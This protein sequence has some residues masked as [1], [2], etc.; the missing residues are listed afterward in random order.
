MNGRKVAASSQLSLANTRQAM[1]LRKAPAVSV[2][3]PL[4]AR[5]GQ[6]MRDGARLSYVRSRIKDVLEIMGWLAWPC[7]EV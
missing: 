2:N 5:C 3:W 7:Y 1:D 4:L 6:T